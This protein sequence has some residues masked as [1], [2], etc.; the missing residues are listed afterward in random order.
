MTEVVTRALKMRHIL[1]PKQEITDDLAPYLSKL[2]VMNAD[3]LLSPYVRSNKTA[4]GIHLI[5]K[6]SDEDIYQGKVALV[7]KMGPLAF[8][9]DPERGIKFI[10]RQPAIGDWVVY[11]LSDTSQFAIG[12]RTVRWIPDVSIKGIYDG[13]PDELM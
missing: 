4:G 13:S 3:V 12:K 10:G 11:R 7:V 2:L 6:T 5:D 9:D 8:K 1:N